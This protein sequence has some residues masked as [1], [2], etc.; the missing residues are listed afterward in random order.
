MNIKRVIWEKDDSSWGVG[1]LLLIQCSCNFTFRTKITFGDRLQRIKCHSC[2]A[3]RF[4][5]DI[6]DIR[7]TLEKRQDALGVLAK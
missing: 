3:T 1:K 4:L 2:G 7:T 5:K 6:E